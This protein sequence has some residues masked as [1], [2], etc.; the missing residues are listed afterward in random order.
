M[1]I[2]IA[3]IDIIGN[4]V[5]ASIS[6]S[7]I[8]E[9]HPWLSRAVA[10]NSMSSTGHKSIEIETLT[11][12]RVL[13][14]ASEGDYTAVPKNNNAMIDNGD[15]IYS[16]VTVSISGS[17]VDAGNLGSL[18]AAN[19]AS[20]SYYISKR[21][22]LNKVNDNFLTYD[23]RLKFLLDL[24]QLEGSMLDIDIPG[25][26]PGYTDWEF[27][28]S[29]GLNISYWANGPYADIKLTVTGKKLMPY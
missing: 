5:D 7:V 23:K 12:V 29:N 22:L 21:A 17:A 6:T 8:T 14:Q 11:G 15:K 9:S 10:L 18:V 28:E 13:V 3:G 16:I 27:I 26:P 25:I 24:E 4:E 19:S 20:L 1:T 2:K